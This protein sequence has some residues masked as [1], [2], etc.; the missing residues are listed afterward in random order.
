MDQRS[1]SLLIDLGHSGA[2]RVGASSL[3][4]VMGDFA[5]LSATPLRKDN[6]S[7]D[8][9]VSAIRTHAHLLLTPVPAELAPRPHFGVMRGTTY[10]LL[11]GE[12]E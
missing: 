6:D 5:M 9:A 7:I 3:W 11:S 10:P 1:P 12:V 2:E 8:L 4:H